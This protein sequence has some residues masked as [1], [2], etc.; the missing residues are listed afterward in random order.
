MISSKGSLEAPIEEFCSKLYKKQ[1]TENS[2]QHAI[3]V[4]KTFNITD[5]DE[6]QDPYLQSDVLLLAQVFE[7][8]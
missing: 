5:I 3:N 6:Y 8:S 4:W 2:Y 1:I 7:K